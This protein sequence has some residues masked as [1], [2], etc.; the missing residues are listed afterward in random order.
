MG[1]ARRLQHPG[2][3][4][5]ATDR[6]APRLTRAGPSHR[7]LSSL[8]RTQTPPLPAPQAGGS[9]RFADILQQNY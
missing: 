2:L 4:F 3:G 7:A 5:A 1:G 8:P 6:T 9:P